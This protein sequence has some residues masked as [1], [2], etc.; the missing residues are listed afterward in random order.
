ME[1]TLYT[2]RQAHLV[3]RLKLARVENKLD[4]SEAARMLGTTQ[5]FIS[6]VESGQ[7]RVDV[8]QLQ[9]FAKIYR[10]KLA[11]FFE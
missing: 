6:K 8:I 5:S 9:E 10:K 4:Q 1:K 3:A 2:K 7:R 11:Y